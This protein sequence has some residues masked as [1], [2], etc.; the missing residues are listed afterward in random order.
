[1]HCVHTGEEYSLRPL[2]CSRVE[3]K[4]RERRDAAEEASASEAESSGRSSGSR[5][6]SEN[7]R[8]EKLSYCS[9]D[10]SMLEQSST[11]GDEALKAKKKPLATHDTGDD[12]DKLN[13]AA[14]HTHTSWQND[15]FVLTDNRSFPDV[16]MRVKEKWATDE[17]LGTTN[18]SKT[19]VE[20]GS[21][22][23]LAW[24]IADSL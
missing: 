9:T 12:D 13:K 18:K 23:L 2:E 4:K 5:Y 19:L 17:Y 10:D 20:R 22:R 7:L 1:M 16:R 8:E 15:Y 6:G 14:P 11:S 3:A 21:F 24:R